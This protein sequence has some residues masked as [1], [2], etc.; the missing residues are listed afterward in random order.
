MSGE[1]SELVSVG[2]PVP[3]QCYHA[4][5]TQRGATGSLDLGCYLLTSPYSPCGSTNL[6]A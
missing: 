5:A 1:S 3:H 4:F 6:N 2:S